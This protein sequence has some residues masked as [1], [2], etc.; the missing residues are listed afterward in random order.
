VMVLAESFFTAGV[1]DL[2]LRV[3][4]LGGLAGLSV[5]ALT[6]FLRDIIQDSWVMTWL[7]VISLRE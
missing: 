5:L 4:T 1:A 3:T 2:D 7:L 6:S